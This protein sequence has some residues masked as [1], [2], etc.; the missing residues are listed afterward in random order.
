MLFRSIDHHGNRVAAML[1]GPRQV[2]IVA[3]VNKIVENER[4]A[5]SRIKTEACPPN[6]I[7]LGLDT[8]CALNGTCV[9]CVNPKTTLCAHMVVTRLNVINGRVKVLLVNED[10]GF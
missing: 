1:F 3:G 9:N 8:P 10:L 7:R 2:I 5:I 6:A 4:M